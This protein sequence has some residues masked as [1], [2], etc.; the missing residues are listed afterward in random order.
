MTGNRGV[1]IAFCRDANGVY[2]GVSAVIFSGITDPAVLEVP[3]YR[4]S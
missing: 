2:Q 4:D 3:S 1:T